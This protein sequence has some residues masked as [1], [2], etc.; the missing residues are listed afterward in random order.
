MVQ[1]NLSNLNLATVNANKTMV[2]MNK[3]YLQATCCYAQVTTDIVATPLAPVEIGL[4]KGTVLPVN[5]FGILKITENIPSGATLPFKALKKETLPV[6]G[7]NNAISQPFV[8]ATGNTNIVI[9]NN[10]A[11]TGIVN[12]ICDITTSEI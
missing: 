7:N 11:A 5:L 10:L 9:N 8:K 12:I 6:N 1:I 3:Q 4:Y 2:L